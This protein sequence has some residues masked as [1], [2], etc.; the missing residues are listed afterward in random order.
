MKGTSV[1]RPY[2]CVPPEQAPVAP[3]RATARAAAARRRAVGM[4]AVT[5]PAPRGGDVSRPY[6][7]GVEH[8]V[9]EDARE[10][11]LLAH[12][13]RAQ[14]RPAARQLHLGAVREP[15]LRADAEVA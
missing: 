6:E 1:L 10:G 2:S 4:G 3:A 7:H 13:V 11:V 12:V 8:R 5:L 9:G 14:K 15:R